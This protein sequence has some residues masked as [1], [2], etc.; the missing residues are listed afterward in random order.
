MKRLKL[1]TIL[2]MF[3]L[4]AGYSQ[5]QSY[6]AE[7]WKSGKMVANVWQSAEGGSENYMSRKESVD[8]RGNTIITI[9]RI[10]S[11]KIFSLDPNTKTYKVFMDLSVLLKGSNVSVGDIINAQ[12]G[13]NAVKNSNQK[14][15]LLGT[16]VIEGF[17]CNHYRYTTTS[18][19]STGQTQTSTYEN[20]VYEPL[21][22]EMQRK[23]AGA[24]DAATTLKNFKQGSQPAS[25]FEIPKDYKNATKSV[26]GNP[27][28]DL[29]KMQEMLKSQQNKTQQTG[30]KK[31]PES[32]AEKIQKALEMLGG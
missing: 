24:F 30:D 22:V 1:I 16:D 2:M 28:E 9:T 12:I 8:I 6:S 19:L 20:W 3:V 21:G 4:V 25:L 15:E 26:S 29:G 10:D 27:L 11:A 13:A 31:Q 32:D 18:T 14:K 17:E 7:E 5:A 23:D